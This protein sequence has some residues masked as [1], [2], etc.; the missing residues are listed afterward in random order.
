[1]A[2]TYN[3]DYFHARSTNNV[4]FGDFLNAATYGF[5]SGEVVLDTKVDFYGTYQNAE[6]A[7]F[8]GFDT[9][10]AEDATSPP[11]W[12]SQKSNDDVIGTVQKE[13]MDPHVQVGMQQLF[14]EHRLVAQM[15]SDLLVHTTL[16]YPISDDVSLRTVCNGEEPGFSY[17]PSHTLSVFIPGVEEEVLVIPRVIGDESSSA[18]GLTTAAPPQ[19]AASGLTTTAASGLTTA[20]PPKTGCTAT[21]DSGCKTLGCCSLDSVCCGNGA[22]AVCCNHGEQCVNNHCGLFI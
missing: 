11:I 19:T 12:M 16:P 6:W 7:Q 8:F 22:N 2:P 21:G 4:V 13:T 17:I 14:G 3:G 1:V 15:R 9:I 5:T 20:A 10:N 18:S